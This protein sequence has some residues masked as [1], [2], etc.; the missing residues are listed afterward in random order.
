MCMGASKKV[1]LMVV[2]MQHAQRPAE[3]VAA[4]APRH[5]ALPWPKFGRGRPREAAPGAGAT[6]ASQHL[7][8][9]PRP[10]Q[11]QEAAADGRWTGLRSVLLAALPPPPGLEDVIPAGRLPRQA[12]APPALGDGPGEL[13]L[14]VK[15]LPDRLKQ[16]DL[17]HAWPAD[18][19]YDFV[20]LPY[21]SKQRRPARYA[22]V[23]FTS[24]AAA[25]SFVQRWHG[26]HLPGFSTSATV[27]LEIDL[28]KL[29]GFRANVVLH[30]DCAGDR[31]A[32][33][34]AIF[35]G[36]ERLAFQTVVAELAAAA[37]GRGIPRAQACEGGAA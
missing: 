25:K 27:P 7:R 34:P 22:F 9:G 1:Q 19:S 29:Q 33:L 6:D 4:V 11:K 32:W 28:A 14:M 37:E 5:S 17:L 36:T 10:G 15:R 30:A 3:D 2:D 21:S 24:V 23:N 35:R 18:G 8:V 20:C 12:T 13:T 26:R 31:E 16:D